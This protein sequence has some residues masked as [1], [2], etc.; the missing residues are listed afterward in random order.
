MSRPWGPNFSFSQHHPGDEVALTKVSVVR[1][2]PLQWHHLR[3]VPR[4]PELRATL[5]S[6][7]MASLVFLY[8][9]SDESNDG[10]EQDNK[11]G[12]MILFEFL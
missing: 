5:S 12:L 8:F 10:R 9:D 2:A 11:F 3:F 1:S 4:R 6:W 7:Q